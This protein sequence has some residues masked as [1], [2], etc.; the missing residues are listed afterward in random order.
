LVSFDRFPI[1]SEKVSPESSGKNRIDKFKKSVR[2][3]RAKEHDGSGL[4]YRI[5]FE[6][7][8]AGLPN[9]PYLMDPLADY[10][11]P[12]TSKE[13]FSASFQNGF[14]EGWFDSAVGNRYSAVSRNKTGSHHE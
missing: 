11:E 2:I 12:G 9:E 3:G 6:M 10:L 7:Q 1:I 5:G 4:G 8:K 14:K 13:N